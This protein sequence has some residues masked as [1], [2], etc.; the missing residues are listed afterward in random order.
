MSSANN[1]S[2]AIVHRHTS[3]YNDL[4]ELRDTFLIK[5]RHY[6]QQYAN[7][8]FV[9]LLQLRK[10]VHEEAKRRWGKLKLKGH[11]REPKFVEKVLDVPPGELC[12]IIGTVYMDMEFKPCILD[13]IGQ[14]YQLNTVPLKPKYTSPKDEVMLEDESGRVKL[15]GQR[16]KNEMLVTGIIISVLG[17][18]TPAGGFEVLD[19]CVPGLA[20]QIPYSPMETET[21]YVAL[22][23]G[24]N[25]GD[26]ASETVELSMLLEYLTGE[27][28]SIDDQKLSSRIVR[29]VLA[30]NSFA[31]PKQVEDDKKTKK[32]GYDSTT[33]D[34]SPIKHVDRFLA[35]LT[36][37]ISVDVMS[38]AQDPAT[39]HLPQP[40]LH[41]SL[42]PNSSCDSTLKT[43]TNPYWFELDG[44]I[45][46]GTSGQ[47]LDDMD[48]YMPEDAEDMRL[49][50]TERT[51]FWRHIAPTC[52]DTLWC[53]PFRDMDP[54]IM[55]QCPHVYFVG[56]QREYATSVVEGSEGQRCRVVLVPSFS[57]TKTIV[58]VNLS[59]LECTPLSFRV[60]L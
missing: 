19:F 60:K 35:Q 14:E 30:G 23:S 6:E 47:P 31:K 53:Y 50:I 22:A 36:S 49:P 7:L 3:S 42:F 18:E 34:A 32:Y 8:Y 26:D 20:P 17:M 41:P 59:T 11:L 38:G 21:K 24:L 57:E 46:L 43:V 39:V 45:F 44:A 28:G 51:L 5:G 56:N 16:L 25:I 13:D 9:R 33:Y 29:V 15:F 27:L 37:S 48:K 10:I 58:L 55:Q 4:P 2:T 12:Y 54:F 40:P 52:P 1:H